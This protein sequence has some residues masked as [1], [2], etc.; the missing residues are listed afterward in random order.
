MN[1]LTEP[2]GYQYMLNAMWVSAMV[3]GLCAFISCYLMLKGWSLIG[4][5]LSHSIVPGVAG[6]YMLG[7][8]FALGAFLSGGLAAGSMLFLNQR[9]RLKEDA[10]IGLIFS[11][12][13]GIGLFMVSLNPMSVNIQTIILGNVLA[14]APEDILQLAIIGVI[15]LTILFLKWKDLM[16]VFFDENH[17][18]SIGL[19][20]GRL[21]LL[22]FTLLSVSTVAALQTV[23][24]FL[25]ICLVVTPGATAWLLTD[26]FPRLLTIAVAIGSLTSFFG[27]WLS[28]W[29]DGAT[30]GIIVVL[31]TLLFLLA[32]V[33]AP[34]HGLLAN[35]RRAR[36]V[37]KEL[38]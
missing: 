32:F 3:G 1:W 2:F 11:S 13:F 31:Q 33:F 18:R 19:N 15:S 27:A 7:L 4:D 34:K 38:I 36:Q 12:F 37:N 6:A 16:V 21:K 30:G 28:Y 8:P 20:P 17:A 29:L 35:R 14:I 10:I 22:F 23:G 26:R 5:A 24:A 9:S 25:V